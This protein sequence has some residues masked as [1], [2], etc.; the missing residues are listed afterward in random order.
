MN[1]IHVGDPDSYNRIFNAFYEIFFDSKLGVNIY[2]ATQLKDPAKFLEKHPIL[3]VPAYFISDDA[4]LEFMN[5]YSQLGGHLILGP[6]TGYGNVYGTIR[7][8]VPPRTI[9]HASKTTYNETSNLNKPAKVSSSQITSPT[10]GIS[11]SAIGWVDLLL[12]EGSDVLASYEDPFLSKYPAITTTSNGAGRVT[13]IGTVPTQDLGKSIGD[14]IKNI[15]SFKSNINCHADSFT[16]N[17]ALTK[18][19]QVLHFLFNWGWERVEAQ[20]EKN[21]FDI[22]SGEEISNQDKVTLGPWDVKILMEK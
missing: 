19:D 1:G 4:I 22:E 3:C 11:G 16:T 17:S 6:R 9:R 15:H 12:S 2:G 8:D 10:S 18:N 21:C 7:V 14:W 20:I 5:E 13:T